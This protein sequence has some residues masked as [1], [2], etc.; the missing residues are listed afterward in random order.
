MNKSTI[1]QVEREISQRIRSL[2]NNQLGIRPSQII[3]HCFDK[4]IVITIG[5]SVTQVEQTLIEENYKKL[6]EEVRLSLNKIIKSRIKDLIE[7]I[8]DK[9]VIDV[10]SNS[11][12]TTN[13]TGIIAILD[14]SPVV[15]NSE[16]ISKLNLNT[17]AD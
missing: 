9:N 5:D 7:E 1:G 4:E 10:I 3:C 12:L 17:V 13:R 15:R 2:Y 16:S 6:A 8:T 11:S 14:Q